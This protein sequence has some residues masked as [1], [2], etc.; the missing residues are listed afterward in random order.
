MNP[1]LQKNPKDTKVL[2]AMSGGVDSSVTAV[3]LKNQGYQVVGVH[4]QLSDQG[5]E[6]LEKLGGRCC[7]VVDS[8]DARRVCDKLGIPFFMI[9]AQ[10]VFKADVIDYFVHEYLLSRTPIPC[11]ECNTK[12]KFNYLFQKADELGCDFVA[13]GHY[14]QVAHEL[15][16]GHAH[17]KRAVDPQ[18]DQ[19]YFLFGMTQKALQRT[20]MPIGSLTKMMVRKL[21]EEH[22]LVNAAKPDS[23]EICFINSDGYKAFIEKNTSSELRPGGPIKTKDGEVLGEHQGL[24]R[25]TIGQRKGLELNSKEHQNFYVVDFDPKSKALIV[26]PEEDLFQKELIVSPVN[27]IQPVDTFSPF[28]CHARIRSQHQEAE[29]QVTVFENSTVLV[30]FKNPQRAITPGQAVVFY[31]EGEVLGG[32]FIEK[33]GPFNDPFLIKTSRNNAVPSQ[34]PGM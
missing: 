18:K 17:L 30:K 31:K 23:Q 21:A 14:A 19:T 26:G 29:C 10:D 32:G 3:L 28:E 24:F 1:N 22:G 20:M 8:N 6:N 7:S 9:N 2:V 15:T 11:A 25:Y 34:N 13:T 4:L 16:T 27:W 33:R 5:D 12:I